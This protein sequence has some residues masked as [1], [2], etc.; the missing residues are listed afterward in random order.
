MTLSL[1]T[2]LP[3]VCPTSPISL[4]TVWRPQWMVSR[5]S[6]TAQHVHRNK[7]PETSLVTHLPHFKSP[8]RHRL[9]VTLGNLPLQSLPCFPFSHSSIGQWHHEWHLHSSISCG[10]LFSTSPSAKFSSWKDV[11]SEMPWGYLLPCMLLKIKC[12]NVV[13]LLVWVAHL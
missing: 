3:C 13:S 6:L 8:C 11:S 2:T 1:L 9:T 10:H 12:L 7:V 4:L 5:R